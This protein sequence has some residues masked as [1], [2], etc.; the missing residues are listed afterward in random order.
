MKTAFVKCALVSAAA[1]LVAGVFLNMDTRQIMK[2]E[3]AA[4]SERSY[5]VEK[6][7]IP[8]DAV[9][10]VIV[11]ADGLSANVSM[12]VKTNTNTDPDAA[13]EEAVC[14]WMEAVS[15]DEGLIG[16]KGM[17]KTVEGDEKT[18]VGLYKMNTPFGT[19]A[20]QEGFPANYLQ[21]DS[22]YYW[23]GDSDSDR[24]N[25]LVNTDT[26]NNFNKAKSE[27]LATYGGIAY[28]YCIDTGYNIEGTPRRGSALFLHCSAGKNTAGCIAIPE[29][30][31]VEIMK[32][33]VEGGTY[34]LLDTKGNFAQYYRQETDTKADV[35]AD[36]N[37]ETAA[38]QGELSSEDVKKGPC[39]L[40][41][42]CE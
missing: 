39:V 25:Q 16:R 32:G 38:S 33:Y 21:V 42:S 29:T 27:H 7:N 1:A 13:A 4:M 20:A 3:A 12:Y 22:R 35:P 37:P 40:S 30:P 23:N 15:T 31:M 34:I 5:E 17:G 24:Y 41:G 10:L 11:E 6:L 8:Q 36:V 9:R 14:T 19:E 28:H 18:P 26:Y 2:A